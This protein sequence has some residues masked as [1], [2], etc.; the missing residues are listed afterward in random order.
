MISVKQRNLSF[1]KEKVL[2]K[3]IDHPLLNYI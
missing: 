1:K 2:L 3:G